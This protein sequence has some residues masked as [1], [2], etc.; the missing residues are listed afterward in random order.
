[1]LVGVAGCGV[2][3]EQGARELEDAIGEELGT[4]AVVSV[5]PDDESITL[6]DDSGSLT[7]GTDLRAPDW[8]DPATPLPDDFSFD[9]V[10]TADQISSARGTTT[11]DTSELAAFYS[12]A[13]EELGWPVDSTTT[14]EDF[15]QLFT[16]DSSGEQLDIEYWDGKLGFIVGRNRPN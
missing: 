12:T 11:L 6:D 2:A 16:T 7:M 5:D 8:L 10:I 3:E 9:S 4:D 15:F 13:L 1:M 14:R